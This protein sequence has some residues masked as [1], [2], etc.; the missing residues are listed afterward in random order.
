MFNST[1]QVQ[2]G[3]HQEAPVNY[4]KALADFSQYSIKAIDIKALSDKVVNMIAKSINI[5]FC[6]IL[7]HVPENNCFI[8]KSGTGW[9][10]AVAENSVIDV[11]D[12]SLS[13]YTV[14][15]KEPVIAENLRTDKRFDVA[16]LLKRYRIA[17]SITVNI[18][19]G[20]NLFGVLA[21][22]SIRKR[23]F[24]E[25]DIYF[26]TAMA[27]IL[28]MSINYIT[29]QGKQRVLS[30]TIEQCDNIVMIT[31]TKGKINYIN[32]KY[33]ERTGYTEEEILGGEIDI[34]ELNRSQ[35]DEFDHFWNGINS[36]NQS[37]NE[38]EH[39][40][41]EK[42]NCWE[43]VKVSPLKDKKGVVTNFLVVKKNISLPIIGKK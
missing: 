28:A 31:D 6:N 32:H 39:N 4:E 27:N 41:K 42:S 29:Q 23:K 8:M 14:M 33:V 20:K 36:G 16:G 43:K 38:F 15:N 12:N 9:N 22:Y 30:K 3:S 25:S 24:T 35:P 2:D 10:G 26:L 5:D 7:K 13:K 37:I 21:V 11:R 40:K 17:S 34:F 1:K 19:E 18:N